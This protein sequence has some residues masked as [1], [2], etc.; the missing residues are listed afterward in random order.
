MTPLVVI[1]AL[2]GASLLI[3]R[4]MDRP[5]GGITDVVPTAVEDA[6]KDVTDGYHERYPISRC[7]ATTTGTASE[8]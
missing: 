7:P 8:S 5:F 1:T 6:E 4:D 2:L 3:I